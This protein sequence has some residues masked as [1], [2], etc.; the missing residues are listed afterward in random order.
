VCSALGTAIKA[1]A[2]RRSPNDT[3][4]TTYSHEVPVKNTG[5]GLQ[6]GVAVALVADSLVRGGHCH[7]RITVKQYRSIQWLRQEHR[8]DRWLPS[9]SLRELCPAR[10][11]YQVDW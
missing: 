2:R 10:A 11:L 9:K 8:P 7:G 4:G 6:S 5:L 3:V 1:T